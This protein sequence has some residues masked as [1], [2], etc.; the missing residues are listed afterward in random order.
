MPRVKVKSIGVV[1]V[2]YYPIDE[3]YMNKFTEKGYDMSNLFR[4]WL[5][6][7]GEKTFPETPSYVKAAQDRL[8]IAKKIIADKER[9]STMTPA[10]YA[11]QVLR[12]KVVA[13]H[14]EFRTNHGESVEYPL[15]SIKELDWK[16]DGIICNHIALVN[17]TYVYADGYPPSEE[18]YAEIFKGW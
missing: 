16:A 15:F 7:N 6:E 9:I 2:R 13:N 11:E 10:E 17:R 18:K 12:G 1:Q 3:A 8:E 5:R 14:V 4:Q